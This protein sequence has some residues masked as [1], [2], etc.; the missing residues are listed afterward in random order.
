MKPEIYYNTVKPKL[1][2]ILKELMEMEDFKMF[3]LVG[4][5]ALSLQLGH[6]I[7][8]DI[9]LFTDAE[10]RSLD[11]G[12]IT[13][14]LESNY[15]KVNQTHLEIIGMG[16]SYSLNHDSNDPVKLDIYYTDPFIFPALDI[17]GIRMATLEEISAMKL[18]ILLQGGRKKDFWDIHELLE[19][20]TFKQMIGFHEKRYYSNESYKHWKSCLINFDK[21]DGEGEP[22]CLKGKFWDLIKLDMMEI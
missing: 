17:D 12:K 19:H 3:R 1:K 10:Y 22:Q 18:D 5:T 6:R 9:D 16:K 7:S 20:F 15:G 11:F 2:R 8:V 21:A 4:G 14:I 13:K